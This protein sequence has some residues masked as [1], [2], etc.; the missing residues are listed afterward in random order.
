MAA[1]VSR[2]IVDSRFADLRRKLKGD[3]SSNSPEN[4]SPFFVRIPTVV[5]TTGETFAIGALSGCFDTGL[6]D[7][8]LV[9]G[10]FFCAACMAHGNKQSI[11]NRT[12]FLRIQ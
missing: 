5:P 7:T 4:L 8:F 1:I 12:I 11:R 10:F 6:E 2:E 9:A 3:K